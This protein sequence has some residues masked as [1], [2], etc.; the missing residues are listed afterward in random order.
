MQMTCSV[1]EGAIT[2]LRIEKELTWAE[3]L[4]FLLLMKSL[5][6]SAVYFN[7]KHLGKTLNCEEGNELPQHGAV[8]GWTEGGPWTP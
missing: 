8:L 3:D 4:K 1:S 7:K 2:L 6:V 5:L